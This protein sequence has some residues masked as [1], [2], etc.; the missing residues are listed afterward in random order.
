MT[1]NQKPKQ[2][3]WNT[4]RLIKWI[5]IAFPVLVFYIYNSHHAS[6]AVRKKEQLTKRLKE[7]HSERI[8]LESDITQASKQTKIAEEMKPRGLKEIT[9]PP[10][11]IIREERK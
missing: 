6:K 4:W 5:L 3:Y 2:E 11:K 1:E 7:L 9:N 10:Y 8:S